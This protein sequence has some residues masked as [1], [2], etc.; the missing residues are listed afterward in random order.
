MAPSAWAAVFERSN[1]CLRGITGGSEDADGG[2]GECKAAAAALDSER[3]ELLSVSDDRLLQAGQRWVDALDELYERCSEQPRRDT[4]EGLAASTG[5][6][7]PAARSAPGWPN[8]GSSRLHDRRPPDAQRPI[9]EQLPAM[10]HPCGC[11]LWS[12]AGTP[13]PTV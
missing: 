9:L 4:P 6:T 3:D 5:P 2:T 1:V 7:M 8:S 11:R 12:S 10:S 13:R